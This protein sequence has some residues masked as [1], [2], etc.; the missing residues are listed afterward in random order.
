MNDWMDNRDAIMRYS[1]LLVAAGV[2]SE[3]EAAGMR[4]AALGIIDRSVEF[5]EASPAPDVKTILEGVYA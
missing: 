5:S 2:V 3:A 4:D 1:A